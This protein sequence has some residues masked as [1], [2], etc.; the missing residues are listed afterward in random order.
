MVTAGI[1]RLR[2]PPDRTALA[3]S[4]IAFE[5]GNHTRLRHARITHQ[6]IQMPL[7]FLERLL[8]RLAGQLLIE[9]QG[10]NHVHP[11]SR[12]QQWWRAVRCRPAWL[13]VQTLTQRRE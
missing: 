5:N 7:I 13:F 6:L 8:I 2:D 1:Q 12:R 10:A 9:L 11:V 4:V 3:R